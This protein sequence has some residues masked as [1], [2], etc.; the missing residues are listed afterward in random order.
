M[1]CTQK[2]EVLSP[3]FRIPSYSM[4][5]SDPKLTLQLFFF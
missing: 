3:K 4:M 2:G 5:P 1:P